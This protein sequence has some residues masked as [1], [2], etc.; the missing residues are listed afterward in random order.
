VGEPSQEATLEILRG[1]RERYEAHHK[2]K[3]TDEALE[4]AVRL[5]AAI[6]AT[7]SC[8]TRPST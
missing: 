3:I 5:S 2:L 6:S 8:P 7:G 1:L 4:A